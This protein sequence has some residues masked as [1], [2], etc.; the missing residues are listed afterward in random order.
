[1]FYDGEVACE[2]RLGYDGA[3]LLWLRFGRV[4][5]ARG[6]LRCAPPAG[7]VVRCGNSWPV[8]TYGVHWGGGATTALLAVW[9]QW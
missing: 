1:M 4:L 8:S 5:P 3:L 2:V 7:F 9:Q 6:L